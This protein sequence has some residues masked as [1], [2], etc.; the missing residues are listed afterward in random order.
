MVKD[1]TEVMKSE[2]EA[3]HQQ[4]SAIVEGFGSLRDE[5]KALK[6]NGNGPW[7]AYPPF[8]MPPSLTLLSLILL[9]LT[10]VSRSCLA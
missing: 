4:M 8:P 2:H 7:S 1:D 3:F 6:P 5:V 10:P 9:S